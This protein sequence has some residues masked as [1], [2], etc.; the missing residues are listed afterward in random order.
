MSIYHGKNA[1]LYIAGYDISS[2]V[3]SVTPVQEKEMIPYAV[4]GV[5][6]YKQM[7]GLAKDAMSIDGL[8]DDGY[9]AILTTLFQAASGSQIVIPFGTTIGNRA[10]GCNS[11]RLPKYIWR[12][13]VTD[14]N[15]LT[16]ELL[17]DDLPW[18]ECIVAFP[19]ATKTSDGSHT[20]IDGSTVAV[21]KI[22]DVVNPASS[23]DATDQ[24]TL[25]T[26]LN[27]I[28][29]DYNAHRVST[30]YHSAADTTNV[31]DAADASN[32]ATS[33]TLANQIK[34]KYNAHRSQSGVHL[35]DDAYN[36][37]T[38]ANATNLATAQT[39]ANEIKADYNLHL[40]TTNSKSG[41]IAYLQV[42]ACGGDDALIVKIQH[43]DVSN[44]ATA[45]DLITFTT[46]N[47]ITAERKTA[48]GAVQRYIRVN[49]AGTPTYSATFA[50]V[51]KRG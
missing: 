36:E 14:I 20:A 2:L 31:V 40:V 50:V 30:A 26:L 9:Q 43:D 27:E 48:S 51:F 47:G 11:V 37:V 3:A 15:R 46:A 38:S 28:K 16:A 39:L 49:W 7:P 45:T 17:A 41:A 42:F 33:V 25:N 22:D 23:A 34:A 1:R 29:A 8:F 44:F 12:S 32:E 10:M 13:V 18:D 6:G 24:A 19:K 5:S 35:N 4:Q 21:H